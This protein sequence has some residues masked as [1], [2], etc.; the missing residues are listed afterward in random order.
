MQYNSYRSG[1]VGRPPNEYWDL[2]AEVVDVCEIECA[3]DRVLVQARVLNAGNIEVP[4]GVNLS[5]R[6][7]SGGAVVDVV[8]LA[9]AIPAGSSSTTVV[10]D[11]AASALRGQTPTV[12][13][14]EDSSGIGA[15]YEC[16]E[17]NNVDAWS[18]TVCDE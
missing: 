3:A 12:T 6:A 16:D 10:F 1:D 14:D 5:L 2:L 17:S 11:V 15:F 18:T 8:P 13:A 7:G 4:A 9:S